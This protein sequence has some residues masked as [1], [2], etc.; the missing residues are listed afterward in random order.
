[1][2]RKK[3]PNQKLDYLWKSLRQNLQILKKMI[4]LHPNKN[5]QR[6]ITFLY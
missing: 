5:L 1:M 3:K 4:L 6:F 2:K